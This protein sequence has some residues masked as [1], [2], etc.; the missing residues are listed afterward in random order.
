MIYVT[1][2]TSRGLN[3]INCLPNLKFKVTIYLFPSVN[4]GVTGC[5]VSVHGLM[6][7]L[8][9]GRSVLSRLVMNSDSKPIPYIAVGKITW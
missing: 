7:W 9:L 4:D 2:T 6:G 1:L 8:F 5:F 3:T